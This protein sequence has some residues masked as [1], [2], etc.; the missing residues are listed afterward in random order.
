VLATIPIKEQAK[1]GEWDFRLTLVY[2]IAILDFQYD[3]NEERQKFLR[4]VDLK[5]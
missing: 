1:K 5:N 4:S 2:M 3:E